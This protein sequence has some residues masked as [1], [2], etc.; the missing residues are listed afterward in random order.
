LAD[1]SVDSGMVAKI[2]P[3]FPHTSINVSNV[4]PLPSNG[5]IPYLKDWKWISTPGHSNGH[6][7]LY[8][9]KDGVLIVG[10]AFC[11]L[12]QESFMS[13]MVQNEEISGPPKYF[14][15]DWEKAEESIKKLQSLHPK[16]VLPSHGKPL[17]GKDANKFLTELVKDFKDIALPNKKSKWI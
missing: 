2:S 12:K 10:D 4:K 8:R 13:V 6:I 3:T 17:Y 5:N 7:S 1:S 15:V 11:T 9:E 14:T 16:I